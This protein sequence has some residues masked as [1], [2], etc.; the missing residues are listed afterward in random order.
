L[1]AHD[2]ASVAKGRIP[3]GAVLRDPR[4]KSTAP[5]VDGVHANIYAATAYP[6]GKLLPFDSGIN[7]IAPVKAVDGSR[8]PAIVI[9]SSPHKVGRAETPWQDTFEPDRGYVRYFGDNKTPGADPALAKGNR[10]LLEQFALHTAADRELR[11]RAAPLVF[12]RRTA[13]GGRQKGYPQFNGFGIVRRAELV[14]QLDASG[15]PFSNYVFEFVVFS[16]AP[17]HELFDWRWINER[18]DPTLTTEQA[19]KSAPLAWRTWVRDGTTALP[20]VRRDVQRLRVRKK[21]DQLPAAGSSQA[22][23]LVDLH[24]HYEGKG[25]MFE[26]VAAFI[27]E[28]RLA[29]GG[30]YRHHGV[31]RATGDRGFDFVG[32]LEL[33]A[34]FG[35]VR[36]V[37]LGQSKCEDPKKPTNAV[38]VARTVA[39]LRRGWVGVYVT[40]SY[41]SSSTQEEILEDKYPILLIDGRTVAAEMTAFLGERRIGLE[42]ALKEIESTHGELTEVTDPDRL[43]FSGWPIDSSSAPV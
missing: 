17:E 23:L 10:K 33:G 35:S 13:V 41:F 39:R 42:D 15:S 25:A 24:S 12:F 28:R 18:R 22:R 5:A 32:T 21:A 43:T 27:T 9:A 29:A 20:R 36:L 38:H 30:I 16:V 2:P 19:A 11:R 31:T 6:G 1:S 26:P 4:P 3:M 7:W 8:L 14:V 34:G 37:V 40:T